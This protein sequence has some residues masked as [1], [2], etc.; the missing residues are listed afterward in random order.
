MIEPCPN[1]GKKNNIIIYEDDCISE[2]V[3][4]LN[5]MSVIQSSQSSYL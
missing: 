2:L 1:Y 3:H 5:N 4:E